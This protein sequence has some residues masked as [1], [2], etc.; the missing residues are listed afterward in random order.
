MAKKLFICVL[1]VLLSLV[2]TG[3]LTTRTG[4]DNTVLDHQR[5]LTEYQAT[6]DA[7]IRRTDTS[8]EQ[9]E[10]IRGRADNITTSIDGVI[11]LF[12]EYQRGVE[13]LLQDYY[14]LRAA[15]KDTEKGTNNTVNSTSSAD[16]D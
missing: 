8:A 3:C 10:S 14:N 16:T 9:L 15:I 6:V 4:T 12:D 1:V 2:C 7:L 11:R 5:Q 13:Q